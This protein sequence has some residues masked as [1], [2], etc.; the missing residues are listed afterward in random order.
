MAGEPVRRDARL[1]VAGPS[2]AFRGIPL[3]AWACPIQS[4]VLITGNPALH[5][6]LVED[7]DQVFRRDCWTPGN[8]FDHGVE[9][10]VGL[11]GVDNLDNDPLHRHHILHDPLTAVQS[12][13]ILCRKRNGMSAIEALKH[14]T[15]STWVSERTFGPQS[16]ASSEEGT[17]FAFDEVIRVSGNPKATF[18]AT[19]DPHGTILPSQPLVTADANASGAAREPATERTSVGSTTMEIRDDISGC[20]VRLTPVSYQFPTR[21]GD[22]FDDN[23]LMIKGRVQDLEQAW[24]FHDPALLVDEAR[25]IEVWLRAAA[26]GAVVPLE[27]DD[28]GLT[29]PSLDMIE[30]NIGLGLV[31]FTPPTVTIRFF[32]RL[33]SAPP[34]TFEG[35]DKTDMDYYLDLTTTP[36]ELEFA[37]AEWEGQLAQFPSR[38]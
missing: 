32:L 35:N 23:W 25:S 11:T 20:F 24:T 1:P 29:W 13:R 19:E 17:N 15:E 33:E 18:I 22:A 8:R 21:R 27:P 3:E 26:S 10:G 36:D 14:L 7:H 34:T 4:V 9:A 37:A 2:V 16:A 12:H 31:R 28:S 6:E 38:G 5:E 30:P